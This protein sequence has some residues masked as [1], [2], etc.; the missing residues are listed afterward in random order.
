[1]LHTPP[2]NVLPHI[3]DITDARLSNYKSFFNLATNEEA[4]GIY[5]WNEELSSRFMQLIG[6]VEIIQRNRIHKNLSEKIWNKNISFGVK[7]SN[8]WYAH[9]SLNPKS[10]GK[11]KKVTHTKSGSLKTPKPSPNK[12]ISSMTYGFWPYVIETKHTNTGKKIPWDELIPKIYQGHHQRDKQ[13]WAKQANLD[14]LLSRIEKVGEIRNRVAHFEPLWKHGEQLEER[15]ERQNYTPQP[16]AP[17]P[18]TASEAIKRTKEEYIKINQLLHWLSKDRA[19]D[20]INSENHRIATWLL[21]EEALDMYKKSAK[22]KEICLSRL[23]KPW[24]LKKT[25]RERCAVIVVDKKKEVGRFF[26]T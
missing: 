4:F 5:C 24:A 2:L 14:G 25:M 11:I 3:E 1:M 20:Y 7:E 15:K 22:I 10:R 8:D 6:I 16:I 13:F 26:P 18:T 12:V 19:A 9:I 17:A 23:S 21:S